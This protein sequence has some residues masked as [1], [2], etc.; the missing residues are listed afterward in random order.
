MDDRLEKLWTVLLHRAFTGE[1][2]ATWREGHMKD[3]VR[4]MERSE[5]TLADA[6]P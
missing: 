6:A 4:K 3:L 5:M 2:T 1:I